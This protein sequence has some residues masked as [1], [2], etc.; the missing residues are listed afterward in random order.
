M[1]PAAGGPPPPGGPPGG[2]P[3]G[4]GGGVPPALAAM[5]RRPQ[6]APGAGSQASSLMKLNQAVM[7]MQSALQGLPVGSDVHSAAIKAIRDLAKHVATSQT[8][9]ADQTGAQD[10][11]RTIMQNVLAQRVAQN[12]GGP[13][14]TPPSTPLP[15]A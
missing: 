4:L 14:A 9:G 1:P 8:P 11:M 2:M 3:P 5:Q 15:G 7:L 10:L 12:R 6:N 13:P